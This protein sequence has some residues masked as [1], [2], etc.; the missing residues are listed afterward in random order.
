MEQTRP[1]IPLRSADFEALL[2]NVADNSALLGEC[3]ARE[4]G[5]H[6]FARSNG[7]T[8]KETP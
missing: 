6:E 2:D 4:A 5:W 8:P 3:R 1:P 7:L